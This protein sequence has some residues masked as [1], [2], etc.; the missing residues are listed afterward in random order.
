MPRDLK[1][2][3]VTPL[4]TLDTSGVTCASGCG[5]LGHSPTQ[6]PTSRMQLGAAPFR[7]LIDAY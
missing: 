5:H 4:F 6:G 7:T 2:V 1:T 3:F